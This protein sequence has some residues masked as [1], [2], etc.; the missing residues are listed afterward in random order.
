MEI[1]ENNKKCFKKSL[2]VWENTQKPQS[3][4]VKPKGTCI[5]QIMRQLGVTVTGMQVFFQ[6][7]K[8]RQ[9]LMW[10]LSV[11]SA[12]LL[13]SQQSLVIQSFSSPHGRKHGHK[14][15]KFQNLCFSYIESSL[16]T[17]PLHSVPRLFRKRLMGQTFIANPWP[18]HLQPRLG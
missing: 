1:Y 12:P 15:P 8:D 11:P 5:V 4:Q 6:S 9:D 3:S 7:F 16:T 13:C 2:C 17:L 10:P 18:S 14:A